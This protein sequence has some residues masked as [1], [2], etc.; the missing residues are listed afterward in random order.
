MICEHCRTVFCWDEADTVF[1]GAGPACYCSRACKKN[2]AR[3]RR[4]RRKT[5]GARAQHQEQVRLRM[6]ADRPKPEYATR[7]DAW[8]AAARLGRVSPLYPYECP[9]GGWHLTSQETA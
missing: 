3:G 1:L 6:C 5:Q 9:C 2:A 8:L 4:R 7:E